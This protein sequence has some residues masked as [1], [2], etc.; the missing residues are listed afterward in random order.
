MKTSYKRGFTLIELL[1]VIAI[2]GILAAII[3]ASLSTARSKGNDAKIESQLQSMQQA[4]EIYY[5]NNSN[6]YTSLCSVA[7]TDTT[8]FYTLLQTASWPGGT[9]PGC[10]SSATQYIVFHQ[11]SSNT[12]YWCVDSSGNSKMEPTSWTVPTAVTTC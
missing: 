7:S 8:G 4:A 10:F 5:S 3:L 12:Q 2:I 6:A 1:V 9:A 11:L